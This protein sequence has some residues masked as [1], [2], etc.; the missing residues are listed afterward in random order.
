MSLRYYKMYN[1]KGLEI[2]MEDYDNNLQ[3]TLGFYLFDFQK[4]FFLHINSSESRM[5]LT[6]YTIL[7]SL[8]PY[9]FYITISLKLSYVLSLICWK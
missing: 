6:N 1:N 8:L 3:K 5:C 2:I 9:L 7:Q 4:Q